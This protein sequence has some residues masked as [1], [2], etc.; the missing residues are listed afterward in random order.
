MKPTSLLTKSIL[1]IAVVLVAML[2]GTPT[3]QAQEQASDKGQENQS[4]SNGSI[5][6]DQTENSFRVA[7]KRINSLIASQVRGG[8]TR[9][10]MR[11]FSG[12][13]LIDS[14]DL[15]SGLVRKS[16]RY[17]PDSRVL[18]V[19]DDLNGSKV[20]EDIHFLEADD[21][22]VILRDIYLDGETADLAL[23]RGLPFRIDS[24]KTKNGSDFEAAVATPFI[25]QIDGFS[26]YNTGIT[27]GK[28][29]MSCG[30]TWNGYYAINDQPG[31]F[32]LTLTGSNFGTTPGSVT[33]AGYNVAI[34]QDRYRRFLWS[35]TSIVID[36][37]MP[38]YS[39]P[40]CTLLKI[41]TAS[42]GVLNYGINIVPAI[43]SRIYGQ[44]TYHVA[45]TRLQMG[46]N[47]SSTAYDGYSPING[48][49]GPR[50]GDQYQWQYQ[51]GP[52]TCKHT[53][54]VVGVSGPVTSPGGIRTWNLTIREQN[55]DCRNNV[56]SYPT[57]FQTRTVGTTTSVTSYPKSSWGASCTLYYPP[58]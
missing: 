36:P 46:M 52:A 27:H 51:C 31:S 40:V 15:V 55:A 22:T 8:V 6:A 32:K 50:A 41:T 44:C 33:L 19:T 58:R 10:L 53:A 56:R 2:M 12:G 42:G 24:G 48:S 16:G 25:S 7:G 5:I 35:N 14:S 21:S 11:I 43:R 23:G 20:I 4:A 47:P 34:A 30:S 1:V 54:I 45:L 13:V 38:Y 49:Y 29:D 37:T 18:V 17:Y 39:G 3:Y 9:E 57:Q 28:V 26:D